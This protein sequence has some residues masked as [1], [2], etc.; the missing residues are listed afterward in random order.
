M[1]NFRDVL[2]PSLVFDVVFMLIIHCLSN[3]SMIL[4]QVGFSH[5]WGFSR[6]VLLFGSHLHRLLNVVYLS[7]VFT[8]QLKNSVTSNNL[9]DWYESKNLKVNI[10][11]AC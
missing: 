10:T 2:L 8:V 4:A 9:S 7:G 5:K 1:C 6:L 3:V 11:F